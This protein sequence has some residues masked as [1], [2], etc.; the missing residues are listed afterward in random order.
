MKKIFALVLALS[1]VACMVLSVSAS[2][3]PLE[4]PTINSAAGSSQGQVEIA[5]ENNIT[6]T[7]T[8][9]KVYHVDVA[10][11]NTNLTYTFENDENTTLTWDPQTHTYVVT[12]TENETSAGGWENDTITATVTNHSNAA[13]KATLGGLETVNGVT[14]ACAGSSFELASADTDD[15]LGK[16]TAADE[17]AF[18]ITVSG[19]PTAA[20]TIDFTITLSE[21]AGN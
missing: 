5:L 7:E 18:S 13:I 10:W 1:L 2:N 3:A 20:F 21:P 14:F 15:R 4:N 11:A 9:E 19:V 17:K 6:S 16:P 12:T 8:V